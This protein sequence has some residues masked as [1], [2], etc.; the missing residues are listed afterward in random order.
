MKFWE[1]NGLFDKI[2]GKMVAFMALRII[3]EFKWSIFFIINVIIV[4]MDV[5]PLTKKEGG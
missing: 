3:R 2:L 4:F 5:L 1:L